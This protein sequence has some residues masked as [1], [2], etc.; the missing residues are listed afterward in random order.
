VV[1]YTV[2][3]NT[4]NANGPAVDR[5]AKVGATTFHQAPFTVTTKSVHMG[6]LG[7]K[8]NIVMQGPA[9]LP[10]NVLLLN[11]VDWIT[12]Q[13]PQTS[14]NGHLTRYTLAI[15]VNPNLTP[16]TR[17]TP[18]KL[19]LTGGTSQNPRT[20]ISVPITQDGTP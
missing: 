10:L 13:A 7:G 1:L 6:A 8:S 5:S 20:T 15:T 17:S 12:V 16:G 9:N 19:T 4:D 3:P 18:V 14:L 11:G 2:D